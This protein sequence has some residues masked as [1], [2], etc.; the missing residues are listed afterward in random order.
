MSARRFALIGAVVAALVVAALL[1][2]MV[3]GDDIVNGGGLRPSGTATGGAQEPTGRFS[4][5]LW[6]N[7][8]TP[9]SR[10]ARALAAT[11]RAATANRLKVI[12]SEPTGVWF[13]DPDLTATRAE[14]RSVVGQAG[15]QHRLA[16][17]VPYVIPHRGCSPY[18]ALSAPVTSAHYRAWIRTFTS[19]LGSYRAIVVL[20]P[21]AMGLFQCL[22]K[23]QQTERLALLKYAVSIIAKQGSWVYIDAGH[24][25]WLSPQLAASRLKAAGVASA[26]GFA[27]NVA[28]FQPTDTEIT[29]G[30]S[31]SNLIGGKHFIV[32]TSRNG[33]G[34]AGSDWCNPPGQGLGKR[35]TLATGVPRVDAFL[36]VKRPGNSDGPCKGGPAVGVFWVS[37]ALGLIER[38]SL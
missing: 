16:V 27:V 37:Y 6:V 9:A 4:A 32:D 23:A 22:S 14:V 24:T 18:S 1:T 20:E 15:H 19:S 35:P 5:P 21:D 10:V 25:G 28:S 7:P 31:I 12:T 8:D 3:G 33:V 11:G 36:W 34:T 38:A 29:Y 30:T 17:L 2:L 26:T 13:T